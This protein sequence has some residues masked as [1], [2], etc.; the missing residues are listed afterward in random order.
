MEESK[1][2]SRHKLFELSKSVKDIKI[3][4]ENNALFGSNETSNVPKLSAAN[5]STQSEMC[6][7]NGDIVRQRDFMNQAF[8]PAGKIMR[9]YPAHFLG[10]KTITASSKPAKFL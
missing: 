1:A 7:K 9:F 8:G 4:A 5:I 6:H 10:K 3:T 2:R